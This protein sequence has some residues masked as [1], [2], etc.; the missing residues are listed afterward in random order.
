MNALLLLGRPGCHLC[1]DFL[2]DLI[3]AHPRLEGR[4]NVVNVDERP[5]WR[6]VYG[7]RIPVLLDG[8]GRVLGEGHFDA[9]K[10][11]ELPA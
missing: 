2:S 3:A 1:E 9:Q 8:H 4:V 7:R 11:G 6:E 5:D 10:M